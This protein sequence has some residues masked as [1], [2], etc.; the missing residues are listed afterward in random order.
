MNDLAGTTMLI[1]GASSGIGPATATALAQRG[2]E[3]VLP[4]RD[5]ARGAAAV[6]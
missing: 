2:T 6:A 1:T 5:P 4:A 3:L